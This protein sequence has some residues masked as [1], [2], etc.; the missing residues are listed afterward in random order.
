MEQLRGFAHVLLASLLW[1]AVWAVLSYVGMVA[2]AFW[3]APPQ[4][5]LATTLVLA[6]IVVLVGLLFAVPVLVVLAAPAYAL[7]LR[8]GRA[9]LAS[10]AAVGLVPG[11]V[12]FA[13]SRELGWP[14]IATGLF[15]S[16]ATHWS[17]KVRPNN[18]SKPTPLRGAA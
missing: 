6:G 4:P 1:L 15:V 10:A 8:S 13:F 18:S 16:L 12:T 11:A 17:C 5:D 14:A 3:S 2:V 7:L 9:S